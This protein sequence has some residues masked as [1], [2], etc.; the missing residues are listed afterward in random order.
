MTQTLQPHCLFYSYIPHRNQSDIPIFDSSIAGT[1]ALGQI[2]SKNIWTGYDLIE[3]NNSLTA[4]ITTRFIDEA[5]GVER[6][7]AA[8]GQR[9][10]FS[11]DKLAW[12]GTTKKRETTGK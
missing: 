12:N 9:Y 3:E 4:A 1:P 5:T 2:F 7:R 8:I 6:F 11:D 10:Y